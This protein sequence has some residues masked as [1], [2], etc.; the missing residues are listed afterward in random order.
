MKL[1]HDLGEFEGFNFREQA[2]I[3]PNIT[4]DDVINWDHDGEGEAEFWPAGDHSGV[5]ALFDRRT[6]VTGG[7]LQALD[8]LL[9]DLGSDDTG[10]FLRIRHAITD[11]G[12]D[13]QSVT[14]AEINDE[15]C[16][17]YRGTNFTDLYREAGYELFETY[18]P[19]LYALWEKS[20]CDG[21][22]FDPVDFLESQS[23]SVTEITVGGEKWI[24]VHPQ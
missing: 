21:L 3:Y 14:A 15:L 19:D 8:N 18:Y 20:H 17:T 2:A 16:Y 1:N 22:H 23:F 24:I 6:A 12:M 9:T 10:T 11:R 7:E 4:A 5:A 13:I